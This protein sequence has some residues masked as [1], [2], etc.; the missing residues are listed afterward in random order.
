MNLGKKTHRYKPP[1]TL[2]KTGRGRRG[3]GQIGFYLLAWLSV[4]LLAAGLF[5]TGSWV[6]GGGPGALF[7][8]DTPTPTPTYTPSN[9]PTITLTPTPTLIPAT[10]TASAPFAYLVQSGDTITSISA[11]FGLDLVNGPIIIMLLN[12]L[13]NDS[14]LNVGQELIIP[15]PDMEIPTPTALPENLRRGDEIQYFVLPGDTLDAIAVE[16]FSTVDAIIA[17][18]DLDNPNA[19]FAGQ[20]LIVPV[21]LV[22]P[23]PG[24][25]LTPV[26]PSGASVTPTP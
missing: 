8:S 7:P 23:T 6:S 22:T 15:N 25:S 2:L 3:R 13:N 26:P 5:F 14:V 11:N 21:N 16:F 1:Y 18:N 12:G 9:T 4:L 17:A 24:P 19:I 10:P 20:L